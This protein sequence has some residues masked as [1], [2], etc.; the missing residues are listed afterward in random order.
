MND[1]LQATLMQFGGRLHLVLLHL[2]I[3]IWFLLAVMEFGGAAIRRKV[4]RAVITE[5]AQLV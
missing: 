2:P 1:A 3:G 4:S 5:N